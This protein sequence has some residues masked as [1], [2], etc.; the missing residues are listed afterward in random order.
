MKYFLLL[1]LT[2]PLSL[3]AQNSWT[4][5][6]QAMQMEN[7]FQN[8][9]AAIEKGANIYQKLCVSCHGVS[10]KGDPIARKAMNPKPA[11]FT[12]NRFQKQSEGTIYWKISE[13]RGAMAS[14]KNM[15]SEEE[16]WQLVSYLKSLKQ[17]DISNS[18]VPK[19]DATIDAF[20]FSQLINAK[21]T[22]I[23]NPK[24]FGFSIQHRFGATKLDNS[25][26]TNFMGLDLA[27]NIR[28]SFEIPINRKLQLEIGRTRYGKFYDFGGKYQIIKQTKNGK[29]PFSL[30]VYENIAITTEKAPLYSNSATFENGTP[31]S[32]KFNHRLSYDSQ[33]LLSRKFSYSFSAQ[34]GGELIWR[35]LAPFTTKPKEKNY[36]IAI[37][38]SLRYKIGL[39]QAVSLE[40]M[41][42]S[43]AKTMPISLGYEVASSGNH[44]FQITLTNTDRILSQNIFTT[45]T[46]KYGKDGFML[47]FNLTRYF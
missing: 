20:P 28:F 38:V 39:T 32:Y 16:R 12:T 1:F 9:T 40:I 24:G 45:P 17:T 14:Y 35:N 31:F 44:V 41:P 18:P 36:I 5:P 21:T 11:V 30:V 3:A 37:P 15:L 47:G 10:G 26:V 42:N 27:A 8:D 2:I 23:I 7:P 22:H 33:I 43:H 29:H 34:I 6:Q 19:A 46:I 25:F 4:V 13:G